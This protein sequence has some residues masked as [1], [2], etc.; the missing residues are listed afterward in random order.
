MYILTNTSPTPLV[1]KLLGAIFVTAAL[2][3][4]VQ[5]WTLFHIPLFLS[6]LPGNCFSRGEEK[7]SF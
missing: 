5:V 1:F 7:P 4:C 2:F 6:H 3:C